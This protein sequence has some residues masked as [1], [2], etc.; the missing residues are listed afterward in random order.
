MD[1]IAYKV[2]TNHCEGAVFRPSCRAPT[3]IL[4]EEPP[5]Y[6]AK[7]LISTK[8]TPISLEYRSIDERP[9]VMRS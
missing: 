7:L 3:A 4:V 8:G 1:K 6:A 5:T 2:R 9:M